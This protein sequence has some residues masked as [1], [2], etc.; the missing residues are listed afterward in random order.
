MNIS[1]GM[2]EVR[3]GSGNVTLRT[4]L[5]SCVG[6]VLYDLR[7]RSAGL[8]HVQLP[9]CN[10]GDMD[11]PGRY[12]NTAIP[13]LL[14]QLSVSR[15]SCQHL[16]AHI[17][18]GADMFPNPPN[19]TVGRLNI[20]TVEQLLA[21]LN[22]S[23]K[24]RHCGGVQGRRVAFEVSTG[25]MEVQSLINPG[26]VETDM[27]LNREIKR[28]DRKHTGSKTIGKIGMIESKGMD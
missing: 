7:T 27:R 6:I 22:I 5:G 28:S 13:E 4:L 8:A 10:R 25:I 26:L 3:V 2:G 1:I 21:E 23:I 18:G 16:V 20:S 9:I 11:L 15:G 24:S 14:R 19:V 12:A 17:A